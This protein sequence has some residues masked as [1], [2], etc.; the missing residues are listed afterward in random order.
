LHT[1]NSN[2]GRSANILTR[3]RVRR[4]VFDSW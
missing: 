2:R 3:L 4:P 1:A